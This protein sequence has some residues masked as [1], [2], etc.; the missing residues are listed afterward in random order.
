MTELKQRGL[1][2][3]LL[4]HDA[5]LPERDM[6][7]FGSEIEVVKYRNEGQPIMTSSNSVKFD[8]QS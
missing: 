8:P 4:E 2:F 5:V 6:I 7:W 3:I 1:R